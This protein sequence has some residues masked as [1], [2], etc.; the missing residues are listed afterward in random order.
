MSVHTL[1]LI[2]RACDI[3]EKFSASVTLNK[4]MQSQP[5]N[6]LMRSGKQFEKK[7]KEINPS[8]IILIY[9]Q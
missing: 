4:A 2:K 7:I 1:L 9:V 5:L 3:E 8:V 6:H